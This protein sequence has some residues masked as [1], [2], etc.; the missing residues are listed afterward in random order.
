M[1][2]AGFSAGYLP[3]AILAAGV[4]ARVAAGPGEDILNMTGH[5]GLSASTYVAIMAIGI[6]LNVALIVPFGVTGAALATSIALI[7]RAVW[8]WWAVRRR[9]G[10][11]A[12]IF[13][14]VLSWRAA[15]RIREAALA[16]PAE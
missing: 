8:L 13:A 9:L 16:T 1:F 5:G 4:V 10:V 6:P 7:A 11:D 3:L 14:A 15:G 2:G 12:S